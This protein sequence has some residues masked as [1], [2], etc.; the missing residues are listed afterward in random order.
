MS[1]IHRLKYAMYLNND[2]YEALKKMIDAM[3]DEIANDF[4][5]KE[6]Y[7]SF[8]DLQYSNPNLAGKDERQ[9]GNTVFLLP[10]SPLPIMSL[11]HLPCHNGLKHIHM[12]MVLHYVIQNVWHLL[13]I[14]CMMH[15]II[16]M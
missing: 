16:A 11:K 7:T 12:N 14:T 15:I 2:A 13:Q 5:V 8:T 4:Y 1:D 10:L 9:L 3:P 6:A